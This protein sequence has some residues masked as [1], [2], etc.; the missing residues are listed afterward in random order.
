MDEQQAAAAS[1]VPVE[2]DDDTQEID[3]SKK[4]QN[5]DQQQQAI[6]KSSASSNRYI[7]QL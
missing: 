1:I 2:E 3:L 7:S 6:A 4:I 5:I